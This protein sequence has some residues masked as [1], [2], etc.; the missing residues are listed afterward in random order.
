MNPSTERAIAER[1]RSQ[2]GLLTIAQ[3]GEAGLSRRTIT[4]R[5]GCGLLVPAGSTTVRLSTHPE[6]P[7]G[8]VLAA[9]LDLGGVASHHT[10]A[11]LHGLLPRPGPLI[12]VSVP[13]GRSSGSAGSVATWRTHTSTNLPPDDT[14]AIG[15]I[16]TTSVARTLLGLAALDRS[17]VDD[18]ALTSAIEE[19]VRT[20]RATERWLWWLLEQRRCRGRNGVSR[21]EE[22]LATRA[23]LGPTESWLEREM[24][25]LIERAHLPRPI[26]QRVVRRRGAFVARVDFAYEREGVVL[27]AL[28][29]AS[30]SSRPALTA[31]AARA[32]RL[33]LLGLAVH[34]FTY[35]QIV[36]DPRW[37]TTTVAAALAA[38]GT[39]E[40]LIRPAAGF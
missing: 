7:Q 37:V 39:G 34:Q 9:C 13:K 28:G 14:L 5:I 27:E 20:R 21:F 17:E 38:A 25:S 26:V 2:L 1:A 19:A 31:D 40:R 16:P 23:R 33:Q 18:E 24:L 11:W 12:D 4:R 36:R 15:P 32:S 10:A 3:L 29:Y 22:A 35:D 8:N 30:H 6:S